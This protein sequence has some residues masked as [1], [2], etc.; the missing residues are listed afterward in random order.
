MAMN[1]ENPIEVPDISNEQ[2]EN[3]KREAEE[4]FN[5]CAAKRS[6]KSS[7]SLQ[8]ILGNLCAILNPYLF[9]FY[10]NH[11][12]EKKIG[13]YTDVTDNIQYIKRYLNLLD[14]FPAFR[15]KEE[16]AGTGYFPDIWKKF[17]QSRQLVDA[18][19]EKLRGQ[20]N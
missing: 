19:E 20:K 13:F 17:S 12:P 3:L 8:H 11:F 4:C 16:A 9:D 18:Y 6:A 10:E 1:A 15:E 7:S 5:L 2:W 14:E